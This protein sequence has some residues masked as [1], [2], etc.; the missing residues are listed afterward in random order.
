MFSNGSFSS[1]L[2]KKDLDDIN[3]F[4][5]IAQE[6][7]DEIDRLISMFISVPKTKEL[8]FQM[9]LLVYPLRDVIENLEKAMQQS[10]EVLLCSAVFDLERIGST[11]TIEM[12]KV[13]SSERKVID[14]VQK[15]RRWLAY[16]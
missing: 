8:L 2:Q 5:K 6:S 4:R 1:E 11:A 3:Q 13:F 12:E 7:L 16:I 9:R 10:S 14:S 15:H